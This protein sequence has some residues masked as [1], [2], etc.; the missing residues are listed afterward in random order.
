MRYLFMIDTLING[1]AVARCRSR[2]VAIC[3]SAHLPPS[4]IAAHGLTYF[5]RNDSEPQECRPAA[6]SVAW[7]S[8]PIRL[9]GGKGGG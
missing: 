3:P 7:P 6:Q 1:V 8:V 5:T 9:S 2:L 4:I